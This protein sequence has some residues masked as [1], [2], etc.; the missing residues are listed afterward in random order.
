MGYHPEI[1]TERERI[2]HLLTLTI[3]TLF[4]SITKYKIFVFSI[5][6][7]PQNSITTITSVYLW[8]ILILKYSFCQLWILMSFR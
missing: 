1:M 3:L 5:I 2:N 7:G 8:L 6:L 4:F